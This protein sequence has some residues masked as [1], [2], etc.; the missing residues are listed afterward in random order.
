M[1]AQLEEIQDLLAEWEK[2]KAAV[3]AA[4]QVIAHEQDLRKKVIS[5][6]FPEPAEGANKFDLANGWALKATCPVTR[7]VDD[8]AFDLLRPK[9]AELGVIA[10]T[11]VRT[12]LSLETKAY[13]S[14]SDATRALVDEALTIKPGSYSL[15]LVAPKA[16]K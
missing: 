13:K 6:V 1:T 15:E 16:G 12:K 14:L 8:A 2:A 7:T 5:A 10:D 4:A 11:L 9:L 3:P